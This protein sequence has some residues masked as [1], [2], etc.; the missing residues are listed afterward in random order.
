MKNIDLRFGQRL[1]RALQKLPGNGGVEAGHD[2]REPE[3][4]RVKIA[5]IER[6]RGH[7]GIIRG[8]QVH[9]TAC[10]PSSSEITVSSRT[11]IT[12]SRRWPTAF[13]KPPTRWRSA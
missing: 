6:I 12:A 2:N 5:P 13:L 9:H 4:G 1:A 7:R 11:S 10:S 3:A 8:F